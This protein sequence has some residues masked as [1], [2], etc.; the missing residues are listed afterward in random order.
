M[1]H[2]TH[3]ARS[4]AALAAAMGIGRFVYT[5]IL[6][7]MTAQAGVTPHAAATLA[8]ANYVGYL[9][10]ALAG[11]A[12]PRLARSVVACRLSLAVLVASLAGMPLA[13]NA[14]EWTAL[15]ALAGVDQCAGVRDRRQQPAGA[16]ARAAR[17]SGRL[18]LRRNRRRHRP[19]GGPGA[20]Q[21]AVAAGLVDLG[22]VGRGTGRAGLDDAPG[23]DRAHRPQPRPETARRTG[24]SRCSR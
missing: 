24:P 15:R 14:F 3:V 8:T 10:G 21:R 5:P 12:W 6:P 9:A 11:S 7:L 16:L 23:P 20:G 2:H 13:T 22:G 19:V 18:G 4:A 17:A 1:Q